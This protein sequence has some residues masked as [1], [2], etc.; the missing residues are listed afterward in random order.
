MNEYTY[1]D[2]ETKETSIKRDEVTHAKGFSLKGSATMLVNFTGLKRCVENKEQVIKV[3][4]EK[5][6][7]RNNRQ[8]VLVEGKVIHV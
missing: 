5:K 1:T 4:Y 6:F 3:N 7:V 2:P 8:Q